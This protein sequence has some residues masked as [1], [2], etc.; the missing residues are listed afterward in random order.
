MTSNDD[1]LGPKQTQADIR[2]GWPGHIKSKALNSVVLPAAAAAANG[3]TGESKP[4][5]AAGDCGTS[6]CSTPSEL[7]ALGFLDLPTTWLVDLVQHVASGPGGLCSAAAL[8]ETCKP[9]RDLSESSAVTYRN[10]HVYN[11]IS[12][13]DH[14]VWKWLA[15]RT[16]RVSGLVL[17]VTSGERVYER[18]FHRQRGQQRGQLAVWEGPWQS[19]AS[20]Q[21]LQLTLR[22]QCLNW[23][24]PDACQWLNQ[25]GHLLANFSTT[26]AVDSEHLT[27]QSFSEALAPCKALDLRVF[28][29][30]LAILDMSSLAALNSCLVKLEMSGNGADLRGVTTSAWLTKLTKLTIEYYSLTVEEPWP[31]LAALS[32]LKHLQ[33]AV[34]ARGDPS[35]LSALTGLTSLS[36]SIEEGHGDD[37]LISSFSSLQP[38]STMQ[39]L[40]TLDLKAA[41][42]P[43]LTSLHGLAGLSNLL[44]V[45]VNHTNIKAW[46]LRSLEGLPGGVEDV[47]LTGFDAVESMAGLESLSCLRSL[48]TDWSGDASFQRLSGLSGLSSLIIRDCTLSQ[49]TGSLLCLGGI[50]GLGNCLKELELKDCSSLRSLSGI[51]A[52]TALESLFLYGCGIT[53]LQPLANLAAPGFKRIWISDCSAVE[54]RRLVLPPSIAA[55][56]SIY[57]GG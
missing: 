57:Y 34:Y 55:V 54:D 26:V 30:S 40:V 35:P 22:V 7:L 12:H 41:A 45:S 52:L 28:H 18:G 51:E 1:Y 8:S 49:G 53:S 25:H 44:R 42:C 38:L 27:L 3:M 33:L 21:D 24:Q 47:S 15:K 4:S 29:P 43:A 36:I 37:P 13:P 5:A 39:Q 56:V 16:G 31:A 6:S 23:V 11:T 46:A 20:V 9:L 32:S 10:V 17:K 14:P 2:L 19:L 48:E 50:E